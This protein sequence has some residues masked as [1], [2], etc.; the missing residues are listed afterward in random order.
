MGVKNAV[1]CILISLLFSFP[2]KT[3]NVA[4]ALFVVIFLSLTLELINIILVLA[5]W[6]AMT[7][8]VCCPIVVVTFTDDS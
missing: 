3:G 4:T 5:S 6:C 7:F 8:S 2:C 1:T